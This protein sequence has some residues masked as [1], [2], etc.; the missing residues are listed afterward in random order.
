MDILK[1][2]NRILY[3]FV[4]KIQGI[5]LMFLHLYVIMYIGYVANYFDKE[6]R[7]MTA[8]FD[9]S[10]RKWKRLLEAKIFMHKLFGAHPATKAGYVF[11][12]GPKSSTNLASW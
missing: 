7:G 1:C 8:G 11:R 10:P 3:I 5:F 6:E 9:L 2:R 12:V 4:L